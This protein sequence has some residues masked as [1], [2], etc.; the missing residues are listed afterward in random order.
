MGKFQALIIQH[1]IMSFII[2]TL[3]ISLVSFTLMLTIPN[4]KI[5]ESNTGLPIWLIAIWSPNIAALIVWATNKSI[6]S[7]LQLAFSLPKLSAWSLIILTPVLV[8][9]ILLGIELLKGVVI[10]W[11]NFKVNYIL[12]LM[13]INLIMGPLGE[14]I[15][16]RGLLYPIVKENYGWIAS[17]IFVGIIWALWH[18]P[19][20]LIESPQSKIPFWAFSIN[21]VCLSFLMSMVYNYSNGSIIL[22]ILFHLILKPTVYLR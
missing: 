18:A 13:F 9:A 7:N 22:I 2:L 20:W 16:W 15:G 11:S 17:A 10:E 3:I 5:P 1:S 8:S 19:L 14:E 6:I 12:P 21:V 4:A